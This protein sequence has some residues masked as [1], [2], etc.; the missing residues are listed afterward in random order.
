MYPQN[1]EQNHQSKM[2]NPN[3]MH[4]RYYRPLKLFR[5]TLGSIPELDESYTRRP[6]YFRPDP[7]Y[8]YPMWSKRNYTP[9]CLY[10]L[11]YMR[12][13]CDVCSGRKTVSHFSLK[14]SSYTKNIYTCQNYV[15][16]LLWKFTDDITNC[17]Q[18]MANNDIP[19][20]PLSENKS[21]PL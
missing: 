4:I 1:I 3:D 10:H 14:I 8:I 5:R 15:I 7:L 16:K 6:G 9:V 11:C 2:A 17:S 21:S 12:Y 18:I 19:C 20:I 13:T